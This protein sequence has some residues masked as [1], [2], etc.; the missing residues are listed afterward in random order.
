MVGVCAWRVHCSGRERCI[1]PRCGAT[2][3][4]PGWGAPWLPAGAHGPL[5][6][7]RAP[8][9]SGVLRPQP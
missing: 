4:A 6:S 5:V 8:P 2:H 1:Q 9:G 7:S 3:R